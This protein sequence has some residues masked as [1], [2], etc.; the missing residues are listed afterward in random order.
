MTAKDAFTK[1][2]LVNPKWKLVPKSE[3]LTAI[4]GGRAPGGTAGDGKI[5][6]PTLSLRPASA[7]DSSR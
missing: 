7:R 2:L 6:N 4:S 1:E 3:L 5:P